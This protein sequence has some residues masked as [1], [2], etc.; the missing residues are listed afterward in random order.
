MRTT[1]R[2]VELSPLCLFCFC[3]SRFQTFDGVACEQHKIRLGFKHCIQ[4]AKPFLSDKPKLFLVLFVVSVSKW[5]LDF[6]V[7]VFGLLRGH[8]NARKD[9]ILHR[10][11]VKTHYFSTEKNVL[12]TISLM[13]MYITRTL[14]VVGK[15]KDI[16]QSRK[17]VQ[18]IGLLHI[19]L[20]VSRFPIQR[21]PSRSLLRKFG[22][23]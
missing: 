21:L 12:S 10:S 22:N 8:V 14:L 6:T 17:Q 2:V 3:V 23:D 7:T 1:G 5:R 16:I 19:F 9:F 4:S 11:N 13:R 20:A 15:E 18:N